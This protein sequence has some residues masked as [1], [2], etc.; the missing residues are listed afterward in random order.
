MCQQRCRLWR[1]VSVPGR[2]SSVDERSERTSPSIAAE[3]SS[4]SSESASEPEPPSDRAS[5]AVPVRWAGERSR[6]RAR[7]W[8]GSQ[9]KA[10]ASR[11]WIAKSS[12]GQPPQRPGRGPGPGSRSC[13]SGG[14][15]LP[16]PAMPELL[17][18]SPRYQQLT[19]RKQ[20]AQLPVHALRALCRFVKAT[21]FVSSAVLPIALMG[22]HPFPYRPV[23]S[24]S[25]C[26]HNLCRR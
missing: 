4:S 14:E 23:P 19:A 3:R 11:Q 8:P 12:A 5:S 24:Q 21:R 1:G 15:Q 16:P 13:L 6:P 20:Q 2:P 18:S 25:D 7:P 17:P 22:D 9:E 10:P 26:P